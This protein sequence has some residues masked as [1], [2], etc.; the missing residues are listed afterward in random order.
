MQHFWFE[1]A[2]RGMWMPAASNTRSIDQI[3]FKVQVNK[4]HDYLTN[5]N[6]KQAAAQ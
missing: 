2:T 1:E 3:T 5:D 4:T 6:N